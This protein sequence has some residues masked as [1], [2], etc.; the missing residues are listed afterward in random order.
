[1]SH[2]Y[3]NALNCSPLPN[4]FLLS[5]GLFSTLAGLSWYHASI[6][7]LPASMF[8]TPTGLLAFIEPLVI[9][10]LLSIDPLP[11]GLFNTPVGFSLYNDIKDMEDD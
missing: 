2:V 5:V 9:I 10:F 7:P 11:A 4:I 8:S 1:M 6:A 3:R